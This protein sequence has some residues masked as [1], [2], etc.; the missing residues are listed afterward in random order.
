ME[1]EEYDNDI[2]LDEMDDGEDGEDITDSIDDNG[3]VS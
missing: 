2:I 1:D 3:S